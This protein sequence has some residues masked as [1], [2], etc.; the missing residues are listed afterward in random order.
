MV[1]AAHLQHPAAHFASLAGIRRQLDG[2]LNDSSAV[3]S[4]NSPLPADVVETTDELRFV[5]EVPG[6][7]SEH[8]EITVEDGVLSVSG[9]KPAP[10]GDEQTAATV[11]LAERRYGRFTRRFRLPRTADAAGI[12][13]S[14]KDGLLTVVV[15]RAAAARA[16]KIEVK[17][18]Q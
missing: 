4:G 11:R 8:L 2:A 12:E 5:I 16:R 17:A 7:R 9:E 1:S 15:P 14:C 10:V 13:A 6:M 3:L 18:A